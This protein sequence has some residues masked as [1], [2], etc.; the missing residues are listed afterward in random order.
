MIWAA[1]ILE[2][3]GIDK[4]LEFAVKNLNKGGHLVVTVQS[5]NDQHFVS[6]TGIESVKK[7]AEI[8]Q[9]VDPDILLAQAIFMGFAFI[10]KEENTLPNGKVF[11]TFHF[12]TKL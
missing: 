1:L 10:D 9:P 11:F 2:Y 8:F 5:N 3:T 4:S 6:N 7:T 12:L